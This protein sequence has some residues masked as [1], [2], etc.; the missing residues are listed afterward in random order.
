MRGN[1][2]L[3]VRL[4]I[5]A[6]GFYHTKKC[7][8]YNVFGYQ[9]YAANVLPY[10]EMRGNYNKEKTMPRTVEV[11]PYQEMRGNYNA[12]RSLDEII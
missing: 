10:Q 11:L 1:Y 6:K 7:E 2:N 12:I 4:V 8:D 5:I 9:E 3:F